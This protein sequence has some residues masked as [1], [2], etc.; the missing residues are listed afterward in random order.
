MFNYC[1]RV[2]C[3]P[4]VVQN[5]LALNPRVKTH[6]QIVSTASKKKEKKKWKRNPERGC[7]VRHTTKQLSL[8]RNIEVSPALC[9]PS[10]LNITILF[11]FFSFDLS[12]LC[13]V[14]EQL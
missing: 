5:I 4:A 13:E 10:L 7:D 11:F 12:V 6:A 8:D 3:G 14:G 1:H 2:C 9:F